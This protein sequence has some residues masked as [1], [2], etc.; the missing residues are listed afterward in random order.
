MK[1][2]LFKIL[3]L[4]ILSIFLYNC[5]DE[6]KA[7]TN[8]LN[9]ENHSKS[10]TLETSNVN[11][12]S[13]VETKYKDSI[14]L[15]SLVRKVYKWHN[16]NFLEDFPYKYENDTIFTEI[17]W[18]KYDKNIKLHKKTNLFTEDFFKR[19]EEIAVIIDKSIKSATIEWRNSMD[20]IPLWHSGADDWCACQDYPDNYWEF[21]T[22]DNIKI[23]GDIANFIWTWDKKDVKDK[24]EYSVTA[25]KENNLWKVKSFSW[26]NHNY[27]VE[28]FDKIMND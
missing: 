16:L 25:K 10:D 11:N 7:K 8:E 27:S 21:M 3:S 4:I 2:K 12:N 20:G 23:K 13:T 26:Q 18:K 14:E 1:M 6:V 15:T 17:D 5:K 9:S 19:H 24:H 22:I 28:G